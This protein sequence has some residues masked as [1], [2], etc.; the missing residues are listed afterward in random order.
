[1]PVTRKKYV[2]DN[3]HITKNAKKRPRSKNRG[4]AMFKK[5]R[6]PDAVDNGTSYWIVD[7]EYHGY[8][9]F[10]A[11]NEKGEKGWLVGKNGR[12]LFQTDTEEK[13]RIHAEILERNKAKNGYK[14]TKRL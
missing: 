11:E 7:I 1:M 12:F 14:K 3:N 6:Q 5:D 13:A 2:Q 10:Y 9:I 8:T 4:K